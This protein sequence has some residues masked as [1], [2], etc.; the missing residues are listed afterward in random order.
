VVVGT[1]GRVGLPVGATPSTHILKP[2]SVATTGSG[3]PAFPWLVENEAFCQRLAAHAGIAAA[4]VA[5]RPV[6][7]LRTLLVERYDRA[8]DPAGRTTR[9]HQEDLC[10]ALG[11]PP[12]RKYE[13][14]GGPSIEAA[15]RLLRQIST[16]PT[17]VLAFLE[18][19]AFNV[20]VG[21]NDAHGKN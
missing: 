10:Q 3:R 5:I 1:D 9:L 21:N 19:V 18:R 11:V 16:E 12:A 2:P 13:M 4:R 15:V 8:R 7:E 20:L 6:G 14:E 17:D